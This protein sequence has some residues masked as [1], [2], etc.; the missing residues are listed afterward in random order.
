MVI[1]SWALFCSIF[2]SKD[3]TR[4][5]ASLL[6]QGRYYGLLASLLGA[7][8][9]LGLQGAPGIATRN[10]DTTRGLLASLLAAR[11]ASPRRK[12]VDIPNHGSDWGGAADAV[13]IRDACASQLP[14]V[15]VHFLGGGMLK[16]SFSEKR[17]GPSCVEA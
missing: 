16:R 13:K 3:T 15:S 10:K 5:L 12:I 7:R 9:L 2:S 4:L 14:P 17:Q 8:T 1:N 11:I 6:E